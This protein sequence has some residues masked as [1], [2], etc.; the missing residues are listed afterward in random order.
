MKKICALILAA[1]LCLAAFGGCGSA[2]P[3]AEYT[4]DQQYL[5]GMDYLLFEGKGNGIDYVKGVETLSNMGVKSIRHWMHVTHFFDPQF[6]VK[7][8]NVDTMRAMI[9]ELLKHDL[10]I[11]GMSHRNINK[12]GYSHE[13]SKVSRNSDYYEEWISNYERG[14]YE[15]ALLFP[16]I[17]IWE[18]D[19]ETNNVDFMKNAE[20]TGAFSLQEM[21]DIS[22]DMFFYGS[23]GIHRANPDAVT[24]MGGFVTWS[25]A[26]FLEM[27]Y[28]NIKSGEFG[29]GSTNPDDYFEALA[30]HPYTTNFIPESFITENQT[31]YDIAY[32]YEGKHKTVYF[33]E[34]GNWD[35]KQSQERAA[36][37]VKAVYAATAESL[38]FVESI[39]YYRMFNNQIDNGNQGGMFF[40]P[41]PDRV[42]MMPGKGQRAVPGSPKLSAYAYQEMAG[43]SGSLELLMTPLE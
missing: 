17:T 11:I 14:W 25:G 5:Y 31:L 6:N 29:E 28:E 1:A 7:Q 34:L 15:L 43:G 32:E 16:E 26:G 10:Q 18:I 2:E 39:H 35:S 36:E 33:T 19:N 40:D 42:D 30:W 41:N 27:V 3:K 8:D 4:A 13:N 9:E 12:Y 22:T 21:S 23:R 38:P 37:N 24:V 20:G